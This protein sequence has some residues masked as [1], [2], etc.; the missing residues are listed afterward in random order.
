MSVHSLPA[1]HDYWS[2]H[3]LLHVAAIADT[4]PRDR[5]EKIKQY[6]HLADN[7]LNH[8]NDILYKIQPLLDTLNDSFSHAYI[9]GHHICIDE[10][11]ISFKGIH[12]IYT[13]C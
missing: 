13:D 5:F 3:A 7:T 6:L 2:T 1:L 8:N 12:N 11:L 4:M 10:M 9:L